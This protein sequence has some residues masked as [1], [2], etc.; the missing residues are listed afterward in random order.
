M[1][2]FTTDNTL[3]LVSHFLSLFLFFPLQFKIS[4]ATNVIAIDIS[5]VTR[6]SLGLFL[7]IWEIIF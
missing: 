7:C 6:V 3:I 5:L 2:K 4:Y 1:E